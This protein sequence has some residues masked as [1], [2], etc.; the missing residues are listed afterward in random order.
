[1]TERVIDLLEAIEI[2]EQ[3][4]KK[5]VRVPR[6]PPH[7]MPQPLGE[8]RPIG[9]AGKGIMK[10]AVQKVFLRLPLQRQ[11]AA[12]LEFGHERRRDI[13][14]TTELDVRPSVRR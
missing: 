14:Q 9:Q 11:I 7:R 5:I 8:Q 10:R 3:H 1:M 2:Q 12:K 13:R 4:R 6:H